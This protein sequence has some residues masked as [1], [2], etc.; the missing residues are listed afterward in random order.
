MN[1]DGNYLFPKPGHNPTKSI[2]TSEQAKNS[3]P[4]SVN[5]AKSLVNYAELI[6]VRLTP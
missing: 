6:L 5:A 2:V 4:K 3:T 1:Q